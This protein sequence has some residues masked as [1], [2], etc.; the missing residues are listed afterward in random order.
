MSDKLKYI[1]IQNEDGSYGE[2]IPF[3]VDGSTVEINGQSLATKINEINSS[4]ANKVI[5]EQGKGLSSNDYTNEEK[6]KLNNIEAGATNTIIDSTLNT[7]GAAADAL[8]VKE[9]IDTE[10][11]ALQQAIN[12]QANHFNAE[13][14]QLQSLVGSPLVASTASEMTD[15]NKIYVYTGSESGYTNGNWYYWDGSAWASGGVYNSVAFETDKTLS[16]ENM[17]ADALEAGRILNL[18][19]GDNLISV[20]AGNKTHNGITFTTTP[21]SI[22]VNGT[23]TA[24]AYVDPF[25]FTPKRTGKYFLSGAPS[26]GGSASFRFYVVGTSAYDEGNGAFYTLTAGTQYTFRIIVYKNYVA[27]GLVFTP[28]LVFVGALGNYTEKV[29]GIGLENSITDF[30]ITY[31]AYRSDKTITEQLTRLHAGIF[32]ASGTFTISLDSY[33]TYGFGVV[34]F[35]E[36][37]KFPNAF[38]DSGWK[39]SDY[40]VTVG[41]DY[42]FALHFHRL[43]N[44][45]MT[46]GDIAA[47]KALNPTIAS[48]DGFYWHLATIKDVVNEYNNHE[49]LGLKQYYYDHTFIRDV[50][51]ISRNVIIP[52][53]SLAN[54]NASYRL[55]F[56]MIEVNVKALSDGN[57]LACHG[58]GTNAL[59]FGGQFVHVDGTTDI[60]G[61]AFADVTLEWVRTN[62]RYRTS[63]VK[64][65]T[66]PPTL[67]E[68][69]YEVK[70]YGMTALV[71]CIDSNVKEIADRIL[72]KNNWIAYGANRSMTSGLLMRVMSPTNAINAVHLCHDFGKPFML[73]MD[74]TTKFTLS[75]LAEI[76]KAVHAEGYLI[77]YVQYFV[78]EQY[79][80][81]YKEIGFDFCA[82]TWSV[83]RMDSGNICNLSGDLSF[84][85]F[86][87]NGTVSGGVL[88]LATNQTVIPAN[89]PESVFLGKGELCIGFTGKIYVSMGQYINNT[90][91]SADNP[92]VCISTFF[93]NEVPTFTITA[94]ASTTINSITYK[95][96]KC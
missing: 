54:I 63:Y 95:A 43:D 13:I 20:T 44:A 64:Y 29:N 27:S 53:Q 21:D 72:G 60:S 89:A 59:Y 75:E 12:L 39:T 94:G 62:V 67:Q 22:T 70:K 76:V 8:A 71:Q 49:W 37:G 74:N 7:E 18:V 85:D 15:H 55:G 41:H 81:K 40:I 11:N 66:Y 56:E 23:A 78:N 6:Q 36:S 46:D 24:T 87:T 1:R 57:Y 33:T 30:D 2:K 58:G 96:S 86:T 69:L 93:L 68:F 9:K 42:S 84:G 83:N 34:Q 88:S 28:S 48:A 92:Q 91:E 50:N 79:N 61:I 45:E 38:L 80:Q 52:C 16:V 90:F 4:L 35:P 51:D 25:T 77:G 82:S 73:C 19:Y 10:K 5:K 32:R 47:I 65:A 3:Y 17:A 31:G 14:A 26:G